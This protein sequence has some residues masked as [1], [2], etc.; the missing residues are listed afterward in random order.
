MQLGA[1]PQLFSRMLD[2]HSVTIEVGE[3]ATWA[4]GSADYWVLGAAAATL[5][6]CA[7]WLGVAKQPDKYRAAMVAVML[8]GGLAV[9]LIAY[10]EAAPPRLCDASPLRI[11][12]ELRRQYAPIGRGA[13]TAVLAVLP[14]VLVALADFARPSNPRKLAATVR[15]IL[16]ATVT[17]ASGLQY[18][19]SSEVRARR[20]DLAEICALPR[21]RLNPEVSAELHVSQSRTV[22]LMYME[23]GVRKRLKLVWR[24][25]QFIGENGFTVVDAQNRHGWWMDEEEVKR[26]D[27]APLTVTA[28]SAPGEFETTIVA[29]RAGITVTTAV[30]MTAISDRGSP[31]MK[32]EPGVDWVFGVRRYHYG[33]GPP[34][35]LGPWTLRV[36]AQRV[37]DGLITLEV[38]STFDGNSKTLS[39][40]PRAGDYWDRKRRFIAPLEL[41]RPP[42]K[43]EGCQL[44]IPSKK[45]PI[46]MTCVCVADLPPG[47]RYCVRGEGSLLVAALDVAFVVAD[48][49]TLFMAGTIDHASKGSPMLEARLASVGGVA[50]PQPSPPEPA[51]PRKRNSPAPR[52]AR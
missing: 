1:A 39:L 48:V 24:T 41:E 18:Q 20:A 3:L 44:K 11:F 7:V 22:P 23:V 51:K 5:L 4:H 30:S 38:E 37:I 50:V 33:S 32:L 17:A 8:G 16:L 47:P 27:I 31:L 43:G 15:L 19:A 9:G 10:I 2:G 21:M 35:E 25:R 26:W 28:P 36:V 40:V 6:V 12:A 52:R 45:R 42:S 29:R 46:T 49:T 13:F 34:S 14:A